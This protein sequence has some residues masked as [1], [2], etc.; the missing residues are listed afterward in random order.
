MNSRFITHPS[1]VE[2]Q[3]NNTIVLV[4]AT[5]DEVENVGLFCQVSR[6]D[7]DIY[8]YK[9]DVDDLSWLHTIAAN[10]DCIL[11]AEH[12]VLTV[13]STGQIIQYGPTQKLNTPLAYFQEVDKV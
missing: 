11:I 10:A 6:K 8:L 5:V 2:K 9:Q 4:D 12:S 13:D 3:S 7:H 1:I